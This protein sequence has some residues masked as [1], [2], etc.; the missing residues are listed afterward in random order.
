MRSMV[1]CTC[2]SSRVNVSSDLTS[3][4]RPDCGDLQ[5]L[6]RELQA[7]SAD[8]Q[9]LLDKQRRHARDL[10][11]EQRQLARARARLGLR[12]ELAEQQPE[13]APSRR[14]PRAA[15]RAATGRPALRPSG[16]PS[17]LRRTPS[18]PCSAS[19]SSAQ[20]GTPVSIS[21]ISRTS[22]SRL[23]DRKPPRSIRSRT[24][25]LDR[26]ARD[27]RVETDLA[28]EHAVGGGHGFAAHADR[29]RALEAVGEHVQL[30]LHARR[31]A[32]RCSARAGQARAR[33]EQPQ[34][35]KLLLDLLAR[36]SRG[37]ERDVAR[38]PRP[39]LQ[40]LGPGARHQ[41]R[42]ARRAASP[43]TGA[44][45]RALLCTTPPGS[46]KRH[47]RTARHLVKS[48]QYAFA[49]EADLHVVRPRVRISSRTRRAFAFDRDS[50]KA[51]AGKFARKRLHV[52]GA[53]AGRSQRRRTA[54]ALPGRVRRARRC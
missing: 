54:R 6:V 21:A 17:V 30:P 26:R 36:T 23:P 7:A 12:G 10:H 42:H 20:T 49:V 40:P 32:R 47:L 52:A 43:A 15:R 16:S 19:A 51:H 24:R 44:L 46:T 39:R 28:E 45:S 22:S 27:L 50:G 33:D 3:C 1:S 11:R 18:S 31:R 5:S 41:L 37:L 14:R 13:R 38:S 48:R 29:A 9:R 4:A 34:L 25:R 8:P 53:L 2:H 35:W